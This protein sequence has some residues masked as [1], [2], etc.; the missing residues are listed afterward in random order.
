MGTHITYCRICAPLCGLVVEVNAGRVTRVTGD[1]EH[2]LTRGFTCPKGR[3]LGGFHHDPERLLEARLRR[4]DGTFEAVAPDVALAEAGA[5][6]RAILDEHGPESIGLFVGTQTYM[7]SLTISFLSAWFRA[8]GSHKRFSTTTLDQSAKMIAWDRLGTW[9]GGSTRFDDADVWLFAGT[10]PLVSM[11]AGEVS[12]FPVHD[13]FRRLQAAKRRGLK[14]VVVDPRRSELAAHADIHLA[15][16]PGTDAALFACFHHV[17]L[18]DGLVDRPFCDRWLVPGGMEAL[19]AAVEPWTPDVVAGITGLDAEAIVEAARM[20]GTAR[21]GMAKSG[22]GPDMGPWANL[23]EHLIQALN[24][25][26]GRFPRAGER[27]AGSHALRRP[28]VLKA[29]PVSPRRSW[30]RGFRSRTGMQAFTG[31]LPSA[32]LPG[33]ILDPGADRVRALVVSGANP[34][35]AFPQQD[36]IIE[37]MK[38]LDLLVVVDPYMTETARLADVVVAPALDLERADDTRRYDALFDEPFAQ[39]TAAVLPKPPGVVED[40]EVWFDLAAAMGL[41]LAIGSRTFEPGDPRPT[42]EELLASFSAK[43]AVDYEALAQHP[44]GALFPEVAPPVVQ[45]ADD[46][47]DSR[48][49]LFP[50]DV[51][52]DLA[53]AWASGVVEHRADRPFHLIVRRSRETLNSFGRR[54]PGLARRPYN[55][56]Y[57]HPDDLARLDVE[58]GDLVTLTSDH[59]AVDAVVAPDNTVRPGAVSMSHCYGGLPGEDDDPRV[60]GSNPSRLLSI[61]DDLQAISYMPRLSAVPVA[62]TPADQMLRPTFSQ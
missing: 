49:D 24:V 18:R 53:A 5:R 15:L 47:A 46:D 37:A 50:D 16:R 60:Y 48:F 1:K 19:R 33:E 32:A 34:V 62:V 8:L 59:G 36:R 39:R 13:G 27:P 61:T 10:N 54:L 26:C 35:A 57:M 23:A 42:T 31:E 14:L 20:F 21:K 17:L 55:P 22:T 52:A 29:Q 41:P 11:Q 2:A 58:D 3:N 43:G 45:P 40:W 56:A 9:A 38:A 30:E 28:R 7:A 4:P 6:L 12:G 44:H 51:A 25:V